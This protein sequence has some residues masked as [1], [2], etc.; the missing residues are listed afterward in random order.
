MKC[1]EARIEIAD[2]LQSIYESW[3]EKEA[4][5]GHACEK[6]YMLKAIN[7]EDLPPIEGASKDNHI[8]YVYY[9]QGKLIG[10]TDV[11]LGYPDKTCLWIGLMVVDKKYRQRGYG[12]KII[13]SL[14]M[15]YP[16]YHIGIGVDTKNLSGL[17]FW[18]KQGFN[19]LFSVHINEA[20]GLL[21][22]KRNV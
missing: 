8:L 4:V 2:E 7:H 1:I 16:T 15:K 13:E 6:D 22:L 9:D 19:D 14:I 17:K 10:F 20:Y 18:H 5:T 21:G 12:Q 11:Y 3:T